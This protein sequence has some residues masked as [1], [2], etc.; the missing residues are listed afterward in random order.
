MALPWYTTPTGFMAD[1]KPAPEP[2]RAASAP[3]HTVSMAVSSDGVDSWSFDDAA[4]PSEAAAPEAARSGHQSPPRAAALQAQAA[5]SAAEV[6]APVE[7]VDGVAGWSDAAA[8]A[9]AATP[10]PHATYQPQASFGAGVDLHADRVGYTEAEELAALEALGEAGAQAKQEGCLRSFWA[11]FRA[12]NGLG[13]AT[14][15]ME[16]TPDEVRDVIIAGG[17]KMHVLALTG[18][19]NKCRALRTTVTAV[20]TACLARLQLRHAALLKLGPEAEH[21]AAAVEAEIQCSATL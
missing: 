18:R 21:L 9:F 3:V 13:K 7:E 17:A 19:L 16:R 1:I 5:P 20:T 6:W 4:A 11:T 14:L 8:A 10:A 15:V 12:A 2:V